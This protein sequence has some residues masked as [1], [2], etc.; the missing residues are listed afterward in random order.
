LSNARYSPYTKDY[1]TCVLGYDGY[2]LPLLLAANLGYAINR[3]YVFIALAL[4]VA[5]L[6]FLLS[7]GAVSNVIDPLAWI[8]AVKAPQSTG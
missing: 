2:L 4:N 6:V 8:A 5:I 7:T 1:D 3:R